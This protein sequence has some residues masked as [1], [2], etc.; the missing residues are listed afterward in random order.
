[1]SA[2]RALALRGEATA[3]IDRDR[4]KALLSQTSFTAKENKR[5]DLAVAAASRAAHAYCRREC[6]VSCI[7]S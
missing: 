6:Q 3:L 5:L 7:S 1:M 2:D 4:V